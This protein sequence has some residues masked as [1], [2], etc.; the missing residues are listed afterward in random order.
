MHTPSCDSVSVVIVREAPKCGAAHNGLGK[1]FLLDIAWWV[2]TGTWADRPILPPLLERAKPAEV[3]YTIRDV[4]DREV[5]YVARFDRRTFSWTPDS[6]AHAI[7]ALAVFSRA[8]GSF[9]V[10]DPLRAK[11]H[12]ALGMN[13]LTS[14]EVWNG[15]PG[16]IE[17]LIRD[18]PRW[19]SAADKVAFDRFG[20][21]LRRLSPEDLGILVPG[22]TM[23]LPGDPRDIP[24]IQHRYGT[25][26]VTQTS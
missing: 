24:T 1:S 6:Q 7:N 5:S 10:A 25:V 23:R 22:P 13:N 18:W 3:E 16:T 20:A 2:A 11:F 14:N 15:K 26:P 9:S 12:S 17:G 21:I 4:S 19:Q 8:N